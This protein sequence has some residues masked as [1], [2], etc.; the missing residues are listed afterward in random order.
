[1][2]DALPERIGR[3]QVRTELGRGGF[4]KVYCAFDPT[5]G[6]LVAIKVLSEAGKDIISR[7]R[8]EA[9]VAGNLRHNNIVTVYEFGDHGGNPFLVMEYLEGEDLHQI[10]AARKPLTLL[11]KCTIMSQV[12]DGL[13]YA[14]RHGVVHRDVK[15]ANIMVLADGRVKIMDFG[16]ARLTANRDATRLTQQGSV[17]GTLLY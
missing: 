13:N 4:G 15:P 12:A 8:N 9:I 5:V 17:I 6:R 7:F 16:I 10:I 3:F 11:Q 14:H 2:S 1:M